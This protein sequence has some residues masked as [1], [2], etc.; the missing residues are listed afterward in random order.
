[1]TSPFCNTCVCFFTSLDMLITVPLVLKQR[2][3][4][5]ISLT[6]NTQF[7]SALLEG[8]LIKDQ[9]GPFLCCFCSSRK[10]KL[11]KKHKMYHKS[12]YLSEGTSCLQATPGLNL[13]PAQ[14]CSVLPTPVCWLEKTN[15]IL[16]EEQ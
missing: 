12:I 16:Q 9:A 4:K 13:H 2:N 15:N 6:T 7:T 3:M 11:K 1:M 8:C 10:Q 5:Y 14:S